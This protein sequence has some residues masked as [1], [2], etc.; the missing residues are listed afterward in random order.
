M[1]QAIFKSKE[2]KQYQN[3]IVVLITKSQLAKFFQFVTILS[4]ITIN[5]LAAKLES[6]F[7]TQL[8]LSQAILVLLFFIKKSSSNN[9][10]RK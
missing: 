6:P 1:S 10:K 3:D 8:L 9:I 4:T 5:F 7:L 2:N